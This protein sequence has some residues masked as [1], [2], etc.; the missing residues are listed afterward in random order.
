MATIR[1]AL[2]MGNTGHQAS[3]FWCGNA[4]AINI[5]VSRRLMLLRDCPEG[6]SPEEI[7]GVCRFLTDVFPA[8]EQRRGSR[9]RPK[10]AIKEERRHE[11]EKMPAAHS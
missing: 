6:W 1:Q 11:E 4:A 5:D 2:K 10:W 8:W 9:P 3:L 7:G